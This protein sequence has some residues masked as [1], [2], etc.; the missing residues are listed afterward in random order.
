[1]VR[2]HASASGVQ[3]SADRPSPLY[4]DFIGAA[5]AARIGSAATSP[6]GRP[7]P[8][9][10]LNLEDI[11]FVVLM[12]DE[13]HNFARA[14]GSV[15]RRARAR[16]RRRIERPKRGI[17]RANGAR[18]VV[19]PWAGFV[20]TRRFALGC[21]ET[22]WT[23][24]LDADEALDTSLRAAL[25]A[26][27]PGD[28][29]DGYAVRRATFFCGRPMLHGAW[30]A[31]TPLRFF[32]TARASL[33]AEPVAGGAADLH[34][35]WTVPG[36]TGLLDGTLLHDSYP[37]L[38]AYRAKFDRYTSLEARGLRGSPLPLCG[39]SRSRRCA[40]RT[41]SSCAAVGATAGAADT[42]RFA[43]AWYPVV[44]AWKALLGTLRARTVAT[45]PDVALDLPRTRQLSVGMRAYAEA[46]SCAR[47]PRGA[48]SALHRRS[49]GARRS[50]SSEQIALPIALRRARARLVHYLSVYAPLF[51]PRPY[52]ITIH[53]LIHLRFPEYFKRRGRAVLPR[54]SCAWSARAPRA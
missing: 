5:L 23:F 16:D 1:V 35:R 19:R 27:S 52:V 54:R 26:L 11:T 18:V 2:R 14:L 37:T 40:C 36:A 15:P 49:N 22:P 3:V 50:I 48:G 33:V 4:R 44:V 20:E 51:G 12:K 6:A 41:L 21:V 53:D 42:S 9:T 38:A 43:S 24:M 39:R 13:E 46:N 28:G 25:G 30:G 29:T 8:F 45:R 31:D 32:R 10:L 7:S 34:E 47:L 17:A